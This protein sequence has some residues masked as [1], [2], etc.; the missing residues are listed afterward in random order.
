MFSAA[1]L[2]VEE[3]EIPVLEEILKDAGGAS[4]S[5]KYATFLQASKIG[6]AG[7]IDLYFEI[8]G[9]CD[10][11]DEDKVSIIGDLVKTPQDFS[12]IT[13][14]FESLLKHVDMV[15]GYFSKQSHSFDT[16]LWGMYAKK[17]SQEVVKIA[18]T[19]M[20]DYLRDRILQDNHYKPDFS[21]LLNHLN[22]DGLA[23]EMNKV[24]QKDSVLMI[25]H[26][27]VDYV[28]KEG[29]NLPLNRGAAMLPVLSSDVKPE[30]AALWTHKMTD[31]TVS[32][33]YSIK[34][35]DIAVASPVFEIK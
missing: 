35:G 23:A 26:A 5:K 19:L 20:A 6:S 29:P 22:T 33:K 11:L 24:S 7:L 12:D 3:N 25:Q 9:D 15:D 18:T 16:M 10:H 31:V 17:P 21:F 28:A 8:H 30:V 34:H 2:E 4:H 13:K 27:L 14:T 32:T 1:Y